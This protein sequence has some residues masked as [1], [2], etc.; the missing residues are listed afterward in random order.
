[1]KH[2]EFR[3]DNRGYGQTVIWYDEKQVD[4]IDCR[5]GSI[6]K[7]GVLHDCID[8]GEYWLVDDS[9]DTEEENMSAVSGALG[10]KKRLWLK[11]PD[12]AFEFTHLLFH[13][14]MHG[15]LGCIGII[16][17]NALWFRIALDELT[18]Q[19]GPTLVKVG[20]KDGQVA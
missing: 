18:S 11:K 5:S 15:T 9:V 3:F 16:G 12:G 1:M 14:I 6:N 13:P 8:A 10:W 7:Q 20:A 17:T 4:S 19:Q 2:L